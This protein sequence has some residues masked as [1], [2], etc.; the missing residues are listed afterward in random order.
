MK[1]KTLGITSELGVRNG[2]KTSGHAA[3][4]EGGMHF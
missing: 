3:V 1:S 2:V 4:T